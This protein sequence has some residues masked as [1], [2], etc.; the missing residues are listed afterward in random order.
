GLPSQRGLQPSPPPSLPSPPSATS[1][2]PGHRCPGSSDVDEE[3]CR[4]RAPCTPSAAYRGGVTSLSYVIAGSEATGGAGIQVDLKTFQALGT[5]AVGPLTCIV[6]F[7]PKNEWAH[8][9]VQDDPQVIDDQIEAA[10]TCHE[11]DTVK[12]GMRAAPAT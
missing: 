11:H 12:I 5:Y 8:R 4:L 6:S 7:D 3:K 2:G 1:L 10:T 9:F